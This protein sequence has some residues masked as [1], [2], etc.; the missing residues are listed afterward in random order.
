MKLATVQC[1]VQTKHPHHEYNAKVWGGF[2][3]RWCAGVA[4]PEKAKER[5]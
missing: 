5:V 2:V 3:R 4:I 1:E